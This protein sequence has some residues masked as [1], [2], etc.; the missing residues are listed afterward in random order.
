MTCVTAGMFVTNFLS[1]A[2]L[3]AENPC[4]IFI[5]SDETHPK[6]MSVHCKIWFGN[7]GKDETQTSSNNSTVSW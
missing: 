3:K 6:T 5:Q 1:S 4:S 2:P 7:L